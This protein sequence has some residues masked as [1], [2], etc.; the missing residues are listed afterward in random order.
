MGLLVEPVAERFTRLCRS[1]YFEITEMFRGYPATAS[2]WQ[3]G[4]RDT[5]RQPAPLQV[6]VELLQTIDIDGPVTDPD[7]L[8][9]RVRSGRLAEIEHGL[10]EQ[11]EYIA[12]R[13]TVRVTRLRPVDHV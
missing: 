12:R 4:L 13:R 11:I 2:E 3:W 7:T 6:L 10:V 8:Q 5:A 1:V 9:N